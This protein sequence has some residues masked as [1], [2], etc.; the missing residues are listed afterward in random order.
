MVVMDVRLPGMDGLSAMK[1]LSAIAAGPIP[2]VVITA[3]GNLET[4][5]H[6]PCATGRSI[7]WPSRS[8]WNRPRP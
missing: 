6:A 1:A 3:F 7:I 8:I 4:A 5:V 2:I